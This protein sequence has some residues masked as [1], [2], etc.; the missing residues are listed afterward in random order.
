ME[1]ILFHFLEKIKFKRV[2]Q[3][4]AQF[5]TWNWSD[6]GHSRKGLHSCYSSVPSLLEGDVTKLSR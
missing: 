1:S 6:R 2:V 3:L 5:E 4:I